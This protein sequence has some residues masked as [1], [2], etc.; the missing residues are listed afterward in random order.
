MRDVL[1]AANETMAQQLKENTDELLN[2]VLYTVSMKMRN[3]YN[4]S[5][6]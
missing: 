2:S 5:D 4:R 6:N 3:G 1:E